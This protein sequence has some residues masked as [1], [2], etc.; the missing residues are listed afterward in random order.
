MPEQGRAR[1]GARPDAEFGESGQG[2]LQRFAAGQDRNLTSENFT[3]LRRLGGPVAGLSDAQIA[4]GLDLALEA[5]QR[6]LSVDELLR[7]EAT[8]GQLA[9]ANPAPQYGAPPP[10]QSNPRLNPRLNPRP[11]LRVVPSTPPPELPGLGR[12]GRLAG[13]AVL[14]PVGA[15]FATLFG[16]MG[17]IPNDEAEHQGSITRSD[18]EPDFV[19]PRTGDTPSVEE[20]MPKETETVDPYTG[21]DLDNGF[22]PAAGLDPDRVSTLQDGVCSHF[23]AAR[24]QT[25][26]PVKDLVDQ[27]VES[28]GVA[29]GDEIPPIRIFQCDNRVFS[30]DHRRLYAYRVAKPLVQ[31]HTGRLLRIPF[32][33]VPQAVGLK[34]KMGKN[35]KDSTLDGGDSIRMLFGQEKVDRNEQLRQR[36]RGSRGRR[37]GVVPPM[38]PPSTAPNEE[39]ETR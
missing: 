33:V 31:F 23:Q 20:G 6:G 21:T 25:G 30:L 11:N 18:N 10:E 38:L 35:R 7:E 13:R 24:G 5:R 22:E 15:F 19:G 27:L 36:R 14:G 3:A 4:D 37:R 39:N 8:A 12:I 16:D 34:A 26:A 29:A 9:Q 28:G 32:E 2:V 17:N 1:A